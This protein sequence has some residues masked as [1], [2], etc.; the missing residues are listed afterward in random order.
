MRVFMTGAS[1]FIG[2]HVLP[3]LSQHEVLC[4][5]R[6]PGRLPALPSGRVLRGDLGRPAEWRPQLEAF[7]PHWCLHLAWE[8]LPD[9]SQATTDANVDANLHLFETLARARVRRIVVAGSCWEYG[10]AMGMMSETRAP[11]DCSIFAAAKNALRGK[12]ESAASAGDLEYRWGRIFFVYGPGQR[13][14]SLIPACRAAFAAGCLPAIRQPRTAQ[15]FIH[16]DDVAE[17]LAALLEADIASGVYNLGTGR[18]TSVAAVA[19]TVARYFGAAPPYPDSSYD[20][21]FWADSAKITGATGWRA[22]T[23]LENGIDRTL[24]AFH[25]AA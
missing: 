12:L 7:R 16:V 14:N 24:R 19:N 10:T 4:L 22:R 21:G 20:L 18:P 17:G 1:G 8:G 25:E 3:L 6:D 2:R 9:Y 5:T 11:A 23:S 13:P 15:D